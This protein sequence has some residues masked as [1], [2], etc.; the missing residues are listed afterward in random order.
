MPDKTIDD[1]S[2]AG[3]GLNDG[4]LRRILDTV[5]QMV[6]STDMQ[7]RADFFNDRWYAFTGTAEGETD[8]D[9]WL[10]FVHAE[11]REGVASAWFAAHAAGKAFSVEYRLLRQDGEYR[12][13][14][15]QGA[16][17]MDGQGAIAR[18]IGTCTD[19]EEQ[20]R[21]EAAH[22]MIAGELSHRIGNLF[23]VVIGLVSLSVPRGSPFREETE[24][25]TA[26]LAA[27]ARAHDRFRSPQRYGA[28]GPTSSLHDLVDGVMKP[29]AEDHEGR[30]CVTVEGFDPPVT[31]SHAT[32]LALV[33]HEL[34]TNAVKHG[35]LSC[36]G[37]RIAIRVVE[38]PGGYHLFWRESGGP[39]V[40]EPAGGT[41]FG[42]GLIRRL[43]A[44]Q[45]GHE[46]QLHWAA[47]GL[48]VTV[49]VTVK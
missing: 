27:L 19:I 45:L 39:P 48:E 44:L 4:R 14:I 18:W 22:A 46:P 5:P 9:K 7:G 20:K 1:Y 12:W 41:G 31:E 13:V 38:E 11:D 42:S 10:D 47:A 43:A 15:D 17:L 34:A 40:M 8:G 21:A 25:L 29:Y 24:K 49:R 32:A 28:G 33:L 2:F 16:P 30:L 23:S 26:R 35:A 37:G 3:L 36:E 6:W